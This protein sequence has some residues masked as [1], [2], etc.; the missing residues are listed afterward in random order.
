MEAGED[1]AHANDG[2]GPEAGGTI[3]GLVWALEVGGEDVDEALGGEEEGEGQADPE[4]LKEH[5][6]HLGE[7]LVLDAERAAGEA[8]GGA[9]GLTGAAEGRTGT[10]EGSATHL[11]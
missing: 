10:T 4:E 11:D 3:P 9:A 2:R 7:V 8:E 6:A 1:E 5:K